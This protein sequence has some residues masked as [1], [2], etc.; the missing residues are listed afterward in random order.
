MDAF[1]WSRMRDVAAEIKLRSQA[2]P[3][4]WIL[5]DGSCLWN[6]SAYLLWN[7]FVGLSS[8]E[9][10]S[11]IIFYGIDSLDYL[12][13]NGYVGLS[14]MDW[15]YWTILF[16]MLL[17]VSCLLGC[18]EC[19]T[20][21]RLKYVYVVR[22]TTTNLLGILTSMFWSTLRRSVTSLTMWFLSR[23]ERD[24][25]FRL[26]RRVMAFVDVY[27]DLSMDMYADG[28]SS[29]ESGYRIGMRSLFDGCLFHYG[30]TILVGVYDFFILFGGMSK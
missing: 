4:I 30:T 9:L 13:W 28:W 12:L 14:S 2:F 18:V 3:I 23:E 8:M 7:G 6:V 24:L 5:L 11:V 15:I 22:C 26:W 17:N 29:S 25:L 16:G 20:V 10:N 21:W 27:P 19:G 1:R